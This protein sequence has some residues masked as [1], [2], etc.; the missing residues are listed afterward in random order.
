MLFFLS[1]LAVGWDESLMAGTQAALWSQEVELSIETSQAG[2]EESEFL[3]MWH[4]HPE[5][6]LNLSMVFKPRKK[7]LSY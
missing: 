6:F 4:S 5:P 3:R 1:F 2:R 7:C